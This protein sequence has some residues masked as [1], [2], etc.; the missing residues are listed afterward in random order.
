MGR[1]SRDHAEK[2]WKG[3]S[4]TWL[5]NVQSDLIIN[6]KEHSIHT[7]KHVYQT[8]RTSLSIYFIR[9]IQKK[10][11]TKQKPFSKIRKIQKNLKNKQ[12][13]K[14]KNKKNKT[15]RAIV[16][17]K[18][19]GLHYSHLSLKSNSP[20]MKCL[21]QKGFFQCWNSYTHIIRFW[22]GYTLKYTI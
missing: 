21:W 5:E 15:K 19:K 17:Q 14:T 7:I 22:K 2:G 11:K 3:R 12:K 6:N 8:W 13:Q 20:Y 18:T 9:K 16:S 4:H 10:I 1:H